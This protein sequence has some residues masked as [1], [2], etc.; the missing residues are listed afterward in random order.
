MG[1]ADLG[2]P[3]GAPL[4]ALPL[5]VWTL[6]RELRVTAANPAWARFAAAAGAPADPAR[7]VGRSLW[8]V[9]TDPAARAALA[10]ALG[11]ARERA[12]PTHCDL[13]TVPSAGDAAG[14][15]AGPRTL[16]VDVAPFGT[17]GFVCSAVELAP[18]RWSREALIDAGIALSRTLDLDRIYDVAA[19]EAR[20]ALGA[21]AFAAAAADDDTAALRLTHRAGWD[22]E[23][24]DALERRLAPAWLEALATG[25][26]VERAEHEFTAPIATADG[27]IGAMTVRVLA[28]VDDV[29]PNVQRDADPSVDPHD[30]VARLLETL[31]AQTAV[32]VERAWLVRRVEQKRR[33]EAIGE[34]AAGVAHELRNPLFGISSAAQLLG[35]RAAGDPVVEKNVGRILR[36]AERLNRII[37]ALLDYG[38]P[39]AA[40]F[41][42]GDPDALW[43][44]VL[45]AQRAR[46]DTKH[47]TLDRRRAPAAGPAGASTA[48]FDA[49]QMRQVFLNLLGN[50]VD[51]AP[52]DSTVTLSSAPLANGG[53]RCQLHNAGPAIPPEALA[54]V[55]ELF[56]STK[57][58]GTG[59]GLALCQRVLDEHGGTIAIESAPE[60]G[61][62]VTLMLP[63]APP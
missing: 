41:A 22:R 37:A 18:A 60:A 36:E 28:A 14:G 25:R 23:S 13:P 3:L 45:D 55:F 26:V 31:A 62:T 50:A 6:D 59:I 9:V 34:V 21:S 20:R 57:T 43:D 58:G 17:D 27:A 61:T 29:D 49:E 48:R 30:T 12:A 7:A 4:D 15:A 35:F 51:A 1:S 2:A 38:R 53:W 19:R 39:T 42:P 8:D 63:P 24:D 56:Y 54:R 47:L 44:D 5:A 40:R 32:A 11:R 10:R 52:E 33:L 46:L 16:R